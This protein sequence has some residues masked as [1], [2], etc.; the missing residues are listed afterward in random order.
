MRIYA[1][2][3][4]NS[5]RKRTDN[6][7]QVERVE[8]EDS[9]L[10]QYDL[11]SPAGLKLSLQVNKDGVEELLGQQEMAYGPWIAPLSP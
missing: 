10:Q 4:S 3:L 2:D 1:W 6:C 9:F 8:V 7:F 5:Y 11:K